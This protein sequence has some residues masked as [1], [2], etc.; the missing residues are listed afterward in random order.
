[1]RPYSFPADSFVVTQLPNSG[2]VFGIQV[3]GAY[4]KPDDPIDALKPD[5]NFNYCEIILGSID[6]IPNS[7]Q[8]EYERRRGT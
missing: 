5:Y 7:L 1:M 6:D 3:T 2:H 4:L 8:A